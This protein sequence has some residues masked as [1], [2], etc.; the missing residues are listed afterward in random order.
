M[1]TRGV[2]STLSNILWKYLKP[3]KKVSNF[4]FAKSSISDAWQ[5]FEY[6]F[7]GFLYK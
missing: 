7:F 4:I 5:G 1:E 6:H 3:L 2:I